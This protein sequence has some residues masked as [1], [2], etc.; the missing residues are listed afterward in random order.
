MDKNTIEELRR[1]PIEGVAE[2]LGINV[3]RHKALCP[4]HD[5]HHASL[6][7][8]IRKNSFRCFACGANGGVIDLAMQH[9]RKPFPDACQWLADEHNI[10]AATPQSAEQAEPAAAFNASRYEGFFLH[11]HLSQPAREFLFRERQLDR[12]VV[13]WCRLTSWRDREGHDWLQI[14]YYDTQHRLIGVQNRFLRPTFHAP[15]EPIDCCTPRFRFPRGSRCTIYNLPVIPLLQPGEMLYIC[16]GPSD[17][18]AMLSA[19]KKAI[20]IPS[21]TLLKG[22]DV[23]LLVSLTQRLK[24]P[25]KMFPDRDVPGERLFMQ[26]QHLLPTL[27]RGNMPP[28]CKDFAEYYLTLKTDNAHEAV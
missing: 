16:E 15:G 2:R 19:G 7:F 1:L 4:F 11:P 25:M 9:L 3:V 14:P 27:Q 5:D 13:S 6:S 10:I 12:R 28:E 21:A 23:S 17:C 18:W 8:N 24:T 22:E 26:L 20:A